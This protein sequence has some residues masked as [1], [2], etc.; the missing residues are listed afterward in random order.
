M[1][2]PI[3]FVIAGVSGDGS[4]RGARSAA[5]PS[6]GHLKASVSLTA[7]RGAGDSNIR[8]E[9][10]PGED[11]VVLDIAGGPSLWLHPGTAQDLLQSQ[12]D[13][14][15]ARGGASLAAGEVPVPARL[16]WRL[17]D[18]APVAGATRG[19]REFAAAL[20][21]VLAQR[22]ER[23]AVRS[24]AARFSWDPIARRYYEI[25]AQVA[26]GGGGTK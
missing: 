7:Q 15:L 12:N 10:I 16:R 18:A 19:A 2:A 8:A 17:E 24:H 21:R 26:Q 23:A 11:I 9:A 5:P 1:S 20:E 3:T 25:L 22:P 13:P 4:T 14:L 6:I